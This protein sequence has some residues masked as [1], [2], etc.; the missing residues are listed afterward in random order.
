[1]IQ[2]PLAADWQA[3]KWGIIPRLETGDLRPVR[4]PT[5]E[6][7][8]LWLR[9]AVTVQGREDWRFIKLHAHGAQE[10]STAM[11]LGEPMRRFHQGLAEYAALH[12]WFFYYYV[13]AREMADLVHQA[14]QGQTQP[15]FDKRS[16]VRQPSEHLTSR[17]RDVFADQVA[18]SADSA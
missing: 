3:R 6:R 16:G 15:R 13:T 4:P 8:R 11:L 18:T 5:L 10:P 2:G 17:G 9:A 12:P 14:E 7:L 1:M